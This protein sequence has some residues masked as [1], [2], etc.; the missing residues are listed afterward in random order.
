VQHRKMLT[1]QETPPH[2]WLVN[3]PAYCASTI[4]LPLDAP[5]L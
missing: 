3:H 4:S 1:Y 2:D 5:I